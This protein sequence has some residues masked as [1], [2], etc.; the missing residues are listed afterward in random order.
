MV[1]KIL[2]ISLA[3]MLC[4]SLLAACGKQPEAGNTISVGA[5]VVVNMAE[6]V[7]EEGTTVTAEA[8]TTGTLY[9]RAKEAVAD[10]A[11]QFAVFDINAVKE[12]AKVQPSG[13]VA[14]SFPIPTSFSTNVTVFY[15]ADDGSR[16]QLNTVVDKDA[17]T[18]T[19]ELTHFSVYVLVQMVA[20]QPEDTTTSTEETTTTTET[21]TTT[22]KLFAKAATK[23]WQLLKKETHELEMW[24]LN[25]PGMSIG[26]MAG[27]Y[28]EAVPEGYIQENPDDFYLYQG[29]YYMWGR[30]D[31]C[32]VESVTEDG[33]TVTIVA[34]GGTKLVLK[35]TSEKK[36]TVVSDGTGMELR[37][38]DVFTMQ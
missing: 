13:T 1:K 3:V 9:E 5:D 20:E 22:T 31:G 30:G 37:A 12:N 32:P 28:D 36:M 24:T 27:H 11:E 21:P 34:E 7:F 14:V 35:R 38:G 18:A 17:R 23:N 2:T 4:V 26:Y 29:K 33:D 15:V 6:S 19:A 16:E 10:V 25:L 8:V